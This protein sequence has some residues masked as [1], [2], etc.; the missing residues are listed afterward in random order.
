MPTLSTLLTTA[1]ISAALST[2]LSAPIGAAVAAELTV[3][4]DGASSEKGLIAVAVFDTAEDFPGKMLHGIRAPIAGGKG[5][6]VF[7]DLPPGRYAISAYHDE[8][9]NKKLDRGLFGIP[10]ERYGFSQDARGV[11]GPPE[12]RDAAFELPADGTRVAVKVR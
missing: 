7:K 10:K 4:V 9:E 6:A 5:I 2:A 12:F 11:G 1:A 3:E 8:N